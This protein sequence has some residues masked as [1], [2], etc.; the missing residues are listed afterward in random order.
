MCH[1]L[2]RNP[3]DCAR[4]RHSPSKTAEPTHATDMDRSP[5]DSTGSSP[6]RV[7]F[8]Q[9]QYV[10]EV[11]LFEPRLGVSV[12]SIRLGK[13]ASRAHRDRYPCLPKFCFYIDEDQALVACEAAWHAALEANL[14]APCP[15][16]CI[17]IA[18]GRKSSGGDYLHPNP[19]SAY[20]TSVAAATA[21]ATYE[22]AE[23]AARVYL[24]PIPGH[25]S[26]TRASVSPTSTMDIADAAEVALAPAQPPR[27]VKQHRANSLSARI[28]SWLRKS[29]AAT[30]PKGAE[31]GNVA[32]ELPGRRLQRWDS[33]KDATARLKHIPARNSFT[34]P[35]EESF[36]GKDAADEDETDTDEEGEDSSETETWETQ[37]ESLEVE[38]PAAPAAAP[39]G[40]CV[41]DREGEV[42]VCVGAS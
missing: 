25:P 34:E 1:R 6:K 30:S 11:P 17:A 33:L 38:P 22:T 35:F 24:A 28:S 21:A 7:R 26:T 31:R 36:T 39:Y 2:Q 23:P 3:R 41:A 18:P 13:I 40:V 42:L 10:L 9:T 8:D 4:A 19:H 14:N 12:H 16:S 29:R 20:A 5:C 37:S 15:T 27:A 32:G